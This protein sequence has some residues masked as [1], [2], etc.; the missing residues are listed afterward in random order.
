MSLKEE[1]GR[2]DIHGESETQ[3]FVDT[4][5]QVGQYFPASSDVKKSQPGSNRNYIQVEQTWWLKEVRFYF[6]Q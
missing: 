3:I 6:C 1:E 5:D 4:N 2:E